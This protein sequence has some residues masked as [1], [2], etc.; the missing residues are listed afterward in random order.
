MKI[1]KQLLKEIIIEEYS[2]VLWEQLICEGMV[3]DVIQDAIVR[4]S[5]AVKKMN[6]KDENESSNYGAK[7]SRLMSYEAIRMFHSIIRSLTE[8]K[9]MVNQAGFQKI[10]DRYENDGPWPPYGLYVLAALGY[11]MD[12]A[13][14][15]EN[16]GEASMKNPNLFNMALNVATNNVNSRAHGQMPL[17]RPVVDSDATQALA[18]EEKKK[19]SAGLTTKQKSKVASAARRGK[20][21]GKKGKRFDK[22]AKAAG[23]GEKG[24]KIAAAAM[25]KNIKR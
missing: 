7:K 24:K 23:G 22:V 11:M 1:S 10:I 6:T 9:F 16:T 12:W 2:R 19:P 3:K 25:W 13:E 8:K 14:E 4:F 21:I 5:K 20:N 15:L 18:M 17:Y